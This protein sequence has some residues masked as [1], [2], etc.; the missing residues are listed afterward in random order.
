MSK[1]KDMIAELYDEYIACHEGGD[2]DRFMKLWTENGVQMPP[3]SPSHVG[4]E[5]IRTGNKNSFSLF[6]WEDMNIDVEEV[7]EVDQWGFATGNYNFK[8]IHKETGEIFTGPGKYLTVFEKQ[9][10][11]SWK[12][13]RDIFNFDQ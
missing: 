12:F 8:R 13:V 5:N 1:L 6:K 9:D 3:G 10:D 11:G 2:R 4:T 7:R